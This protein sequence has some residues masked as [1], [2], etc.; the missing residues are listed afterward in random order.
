MAE[1]SRTPM[2]TVSEA[3]AL[4][5]RGLPVFPCRPNGKEPMTPHGFH[6]ATTDLSQVQSWWRRWPDAN[7]AIATG[8]G[9]VDVL[10]VDVREV[11]SGWAAFERIKAAG[12]LSGALRLVQTPSGGLHVYFL[13]TEQRCSSLPGMFVDFKA[14]GGYVLAPPSRIASQAGCRTYAELERCDDGRSL[15]W[16]VVR[17]L[18]VPRTRGSS[19]RGRAAPEGLGSLA[20][21]VGSRPEGARNSGLFWAACRA[22]EQGCSD[23]RELIDA[24]VRAGLPPWEVSRTIR[25]AQAHTEASA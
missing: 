8:A 12:L 17:R 19:R 14:T 18:L 9:S 11:G 4:A 25:S 15:D 21:W 1:V 16:A 10:D 22:V 23:L 7:L 6:D 24:G 5:A 13:G 3:L 20:N 2:G